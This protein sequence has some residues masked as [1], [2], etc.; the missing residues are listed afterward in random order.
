M[1]DWRNVGNWHWKERN[2]LEWAKK[3]LEEKLNGTE[4]SKNGFTAKVTSVDAVTGDADLNIRKGRLIAIYDV[5]VK[6][7]WSC[8]K[9]DDELSGKI[10]IPEVAHDTDDYVYDITASNSAVATLPLK[11]FVRRELTGELT[12]KL[13]RFTE[14]LKQANGS[15]MY[16]PDNGN[17]GTSTPKNTQL[18]NDFKQGKTG[19]TD[20]ASVVEIVGEKDAKFSTVS[21]SQNVEFVCSADD[22]YGMLT[23]PQR[24]SVWTRSAAEIQPKE[25]TRFKLFGGHIEGELT[26]LEPGRLI[27]QTWRVAT[28]PKGHYSRVKI[29]IEQQSSSTRLSLKQSGVPFN[30]EDATKANWDRYYWNSIKG[31]FG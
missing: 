21:I 24:V 23:D 1:A 16:I 20:S 13:E 17:S 30:E 4:V 6:L 2:C 22:L 15:D 19:A 29:D 26:K 10:T 5:E 9:G 12:K 27:E 25:G 3:Y 11:D 7:S 28:W 31:T 8:T 18:E 14:D